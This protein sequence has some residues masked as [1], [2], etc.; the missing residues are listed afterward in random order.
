MNEFYSLFENY[1]HNIIFFI[2]NFKAN[3]PIQLQNELMHL[4]FQQN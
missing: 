4:T 1:A 3:L 2:N